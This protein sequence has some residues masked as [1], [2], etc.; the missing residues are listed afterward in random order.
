MGGKNDMGKVC[1]GEHRPGQLWWAV[2]DERALADGD[3]G[4]PVAHDLFRCL[5]TE[6]IRWSLGLIPRGSWFL[7]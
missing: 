7:R 2:P 1:C 3:T 4:T 6:F 5:R